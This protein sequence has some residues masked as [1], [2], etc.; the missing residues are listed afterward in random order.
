MSSLL[1]R[2]FGYFMLFSCI[3][4]TTTVSLQRKLKDFCCFYYDDNWIFLLIRSE[5]S[6]DLLSSNK[7]TGPAQKIYSIIIIIITFC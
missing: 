2:S 6:I 5:T 1:E 7:L 4:S 3:M